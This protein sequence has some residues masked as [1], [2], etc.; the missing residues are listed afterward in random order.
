MRRRVLAP[1][2]LALVGLASPAAQD[3]REVSLADLEQRLLA[4]ADNIETG[5]AYRRAVIRSGEYDRALRFFGSLVAAHPG[6]ANAHLNYGFCYVDK[7]PA[8][9]SITQVILANS[10]LTQFS[11]SIDVRPS[12]IAYYTRGASY[13]FWP[14]IFGRVSLG[15]ADL[16]EALRIQQREPKRSY[17]ART[18]VAL[19]DGYWKADDTARAR[20]TWQQGRQAF[21][22]HPPLE[23]R[24]KADAE[25]LARIIALAF[26]PAKRVDT[27]LSELWGTR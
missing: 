8:A 24:L 19:G 2:L 1:F 13:L 10:A 7:I 16:E 23:E 11:R 6:A 17:H 5:N 26:D 12:W 14:K 22:G 18:F 3:R 27:D 20:T 9:G 25:E 15:I 4:D 21:P